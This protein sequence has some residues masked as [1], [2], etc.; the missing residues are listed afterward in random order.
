MKKIFT[1]ISVALCAM[2]INAQ[3][4]VSTFSVSKGDFNTDKHWQFVQ[5]KDGE[6]AVAN[7]EI[8]SSPNRDNLYNDNRDECDENTTPTFDT[9]TYKEGV[10]IWEDK[11]VGKLKAANES[12]EALNEDYTNALVGKGNPQ[13]NVQEVWSY[14][15]NGW[16]FNVT[17][18]EWTEGC[19]SLPGQGSYLRIT[20][21]VD[22]TLELGIYIFKGGHKL[23]I[24]DESTKDQGYTLLPVSA[25]K[26]TG[27]YFQ[28]NMFQDNYKTEGLEAY[29]EDGQTK[30]RIP[31]GKTAADLVSY[32]KEWTMP[33]S[34]IIQEQPTGTIGRPFMGTIEF[35]VKKGVSYI[36]MCP[37]SQVGF[38]GFAYAY[39]KSAADAEEGLPEPV[40]PTAGI[41]TVKNVKDVQ[42]ANAAMY[43]LAGQKVTK[44]FKGLVVKNGVKFLNK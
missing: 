16:S 43:N 10:L 8:L 27:G 36:I 13:F 2:S 26:V 34:R 32:L 38:Y 23:Y 41:E 39:D 33:E 35:D 40:D 19:G 7:F 21:I 11:K 3:T 24:I 42:N 37:K 5:V 44:G 14:G 6:K 17:G 25:V 31:E 29:E 4:K 22:G 15:D 12:L 18:D 28:H 30:Y 9:S 20:P 1:L